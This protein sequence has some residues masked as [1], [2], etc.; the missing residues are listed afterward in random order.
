M[1]SVKRT[2]SLP[3]DLTQTELALKLGVT[4]PLVSKWLSGKVIPRPSTLKKISTATNVPVNEII[5]HIYSKHED[6]AEG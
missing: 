3:F 5:K 6:S 2:D 4:Q 1:I